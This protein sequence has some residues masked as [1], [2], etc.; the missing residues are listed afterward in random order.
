MSYDVS[1]RINTGKKMV[2]V[3]DCGNYTSNVSKMYYKSFGEG[4]INSLHGMKGHTA[5]PF[6]K[7]AILTMQENKAEYVALNPPKELGDYGGAIAYL[8]NIL[9]ACEN[10]PL[11]EVSIN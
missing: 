11:A 4:G 8:I 10:H 1:L 5:A 2:E 6:L 7:G 3:A 9:E